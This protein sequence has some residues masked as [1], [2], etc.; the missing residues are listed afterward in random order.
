[1]NNK[2]NRVPFIVGLAAGIVYAAAALGTQIVF[3]VIFAKGAETSSSSNILAIIAAAVGFLALPP[4]IYSAY[5]VF[6]EIRNGAYCT[7]KWSG[8][9]PNGLLKL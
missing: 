9:A 5:V 2:R 4:T 8:G 3:S 7:K 6:A 1:M